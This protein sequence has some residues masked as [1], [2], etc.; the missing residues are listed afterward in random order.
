MRKC[1]INAL[2][3][4]VV[5]RVDTIQYRIPL[6]FRVGAIVIEHERWVGVRYD[7]LANILVDAPAYGS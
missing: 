1:Y 2:V 7:S 3:E 6:A 5:Q 4:R